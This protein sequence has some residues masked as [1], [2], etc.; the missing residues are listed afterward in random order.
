M[1][2]NPI[3]AF[4][5]LDQIVYSFDKR[6]KNEVDCVCVYVCDREWWTEAEKS[7]DY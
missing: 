6:K 3:F 2:A 5:L 1:F 7:K 4:H